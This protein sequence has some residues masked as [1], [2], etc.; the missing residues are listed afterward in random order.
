MPPAAARLLLPRDLAP[1]ILGFGLEQLVERLHLVRQRAVVSTLSSSPTA[2]PMASTARAERIVAGRR[3][4][5]PRRRRGSPLSRATCALAFSAR[6]R[7]SDCAFETALMSCCDAA[8]RA[9]RARASSF[10]VATM[11][12]FC[13]SA[14]P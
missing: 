14:S 1:A 5:F 13:A 4:T 8:S 6:S 10:H 3:S 12:S 9:R 2:R 11:I 7:S